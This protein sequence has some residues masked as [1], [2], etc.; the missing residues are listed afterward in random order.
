[1]VKVPTL[2]SENRKLE[3][4]TSSLAKNCL[5]LYSYVVNAKGTSYINMTARVPN[6]SGILNQCNPQIYGAVHSQV[7]YIALIN[8]LSVSRNCKRYLKY[9][10]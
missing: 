3:N 2:S 7:Y 9:N 5:S 8:L 1:M 6:Y 4:N 10:F